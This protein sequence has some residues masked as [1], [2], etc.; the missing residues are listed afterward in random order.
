MNRKCTILAVYFAMGIAVGFALA[1]PNA[2]TNWLPGYVCVTQG[3]DSVESSGLNT[4]QVYACIP[5]SALPL[6]TA[7]QIGADGTGDVRRLIFTFNEGIYTNWSTAAATNR[8]AN[9]S[10][11][12]SEVLQ[13]RQYII[14]HQ[15]DTTWSFTPTLYLED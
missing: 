15:F 12:R 2:I 6:A 14:R 7:T 11:Y 8:P 4:N 9:A 10:F 5:L 3:W 1:S 13:D